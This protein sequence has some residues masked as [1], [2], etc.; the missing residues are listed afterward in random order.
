VTALRKIFIDESHR[1][2]NKNGRTKTAKAKIQN[3]EM[4]QRHMQRGIQRLHTIVNVVG[5]TC[6]EKSSN[7]EGNRDLD[8]INS[9]R[10]HVIPWQICEGGA[11]FVSY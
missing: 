6:L 1:L 8:L 10:D 9:E 5:D 7:F 3:L 4:K 11:R 2:S